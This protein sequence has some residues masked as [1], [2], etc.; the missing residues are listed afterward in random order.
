MF[1]FILHIL[2]LD[3]FHLCNEREK[4][5]NSNVWRQMYYLL[6]TSVCLALMTSTPLKLKLLNS[7]LKE[8]LLMGLLIS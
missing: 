3:S 2:V 6:H 7:N 1:E 5:K 8:G 4:K